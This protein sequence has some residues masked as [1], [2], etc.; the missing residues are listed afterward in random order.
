MLSKFMASLD[1]LSFSKNCKGT[2][3]LILICGAS[4][5]KVFLRGH[6]RQPGGRALWLGL[7]WVFSNS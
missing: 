7:R 4:F 6:L 5:S 2:F 3:P 1:T